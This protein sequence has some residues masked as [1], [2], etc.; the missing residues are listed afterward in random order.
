MSLAQERRILPGLAALWHYGAAA[1]RGAAGK[2]DTDAD[3]G[4]AEGTEAAQR[5]RHRVLIL[6]GIAAT[7]MLSGAV[8]A[9]ASLNALYLT[10]SLIACGFILSDFRIGVVLLIVLMPVS[11]T[12]VFP[13]AML[14]ITGL[15]PLNLLLFGTLGACL[16]R[17]LTDGS[18]RRFL[19]R[20]LLW[21]YIVPI[22]V[23]GMLG[24]RHVGEILPA[25]YI[26]QLID[27]V[28][29]GGYFRDMVVKPLFI[30]IFALLV[31]AAVSRSAQP[32]KFLVPGL[33][34]IWIM[35]LMVIV[36][37][38]QSGVALSQIAG[39]ESR[40]FLSRL[41]LHANDLGRLF[42]I[43]YAL[44]LFTWYESKDAGVRSALM[45]TMMLVVAALM[46]TFSRGAFAA[47]ALVNLLFLVWRRSVK[48]LIAFG[49]LASMVFLALPAVVYERVL[50]GEGQGLNAISAGRVEG[51]WLPLL[52]EF[53]RSPVYGSGLGS[54][55]WSEPMRTG[56]GASVLQA[57][58]PHNA[59]L[60]ALLDMG[61][62]G[63]ILVCVYFL[64]V[65]RGFRTLGRDPT[66]SPTL[67]GFFSGAAAGLL[68][69]L[70]SGVSD[71]SLA[72]RPEQVFLWL[73][74]GMMYGQLK[75]R[76]A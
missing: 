38:G 43:A 59:Y 70:F 51:L 46:L 8:V 36:F 19:P 76:P 9:L 65:W 21:L 61:I 62:V 58:H 14:G 26:H 35:G 69:L 1:F 24:A 41:G 39:S 33:V 66:Q 49:L 5:I 12:S 73:A 29:A 20:P 10:I 17:G 2:P 25:F 55:M 72:P 37:V 67:R 50:T 6:S 32:E 30:V 7:G 48:T 42:A 60:Q 53:M 74:I 31:G 23:A 15:N 18:L 47:F 22:L 28:N 71:G 68:A 34:S 54:I 63:L 11:T 44:L 3:A 56:G 75:R 57:T 16:L 64:H 45:A 13:H 4:Y 27:F 40:A 52:P